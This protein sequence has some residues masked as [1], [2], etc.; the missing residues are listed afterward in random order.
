MSTQHIIG[1]FGPD[2]PS[3]SFDWHK[4]LVFL[5]N[6]LTATSITNIIT[7]K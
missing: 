3:Q 5:P 1:D 4:K 2:L 6:R 7:T